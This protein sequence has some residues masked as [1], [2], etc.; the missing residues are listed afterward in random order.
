MRGSCREDLVI[1]VTRHAA[2]RFRERGC[3]G[4]SIDRSYATLTKAVAGAV[5]EGG[6][7]PVDRN[8]CVTPIPINAHR[9]VFAVL[10]ISGPV[11][12]PWGVVVWTVLSEAMVLRS[13]G[14]LVAVGASVCAA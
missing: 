11:E 5:H 8:G 1:R 7:I 14:H 9:T 13:Y 10:E 3:P 12:K 4:A 2:Q 6:L